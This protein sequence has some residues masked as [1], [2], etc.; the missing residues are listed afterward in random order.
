M[1]AKDFL[2]WLCHHMGIHVNLPKSSLDPSQ[3]QDY[4]GM[5]IQT[6]PLRVF[7]DPQ[8]GSEVVAT[9][10][11]LSFDPRPPCVGL[12]PA[13]GHHVVDISAS[14]GSQAS[15]AVPPALP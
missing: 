15:H 11:G 5:T 14:S 3:T 6:S 4:L 8:T 12:A 13:F 2:L 7:H 1:R 9:S 10:S